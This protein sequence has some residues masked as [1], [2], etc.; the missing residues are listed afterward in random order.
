MDDPT[1]AIAKTQLGKYLLHTIEQTMIEANPALGVTRMIS[2]A[3][4]PQEKITL[5]RE[6]W[7]YVVHQSERLNKIILI[8]LYTL[9][10]HKR[11]RYL[12]VRYGSTERIHM[13]KVVFPL[14]N[15]AAGGEFNLENILES[16][17]LR[18]LRSVVYKSLELATEVL[19]TEDTFWTTPDNPE[20]LATECLLEVAEIN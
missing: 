5:A 20:L 1:I 16:G 10:N 15:A 9:N 13:G 2:F 4:T 12:N 7:C 3:Y 19:A 18:N 8:S 14:V 17:V 11:S 6:S